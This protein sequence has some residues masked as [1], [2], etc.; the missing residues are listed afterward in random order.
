MR[1][2]IM[3]RKHSLKTSFFFELVHWGML[4][5]LILAPFVFFAVALI[6]FG[7]SDGLTPVVSEAQVVFFFCAL[8][9]VWIGLSFLTAKIAT[10][11]W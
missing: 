6:S 5:A 3:R 4:L 8:F 2:A 9:L 10:R 11:R 7:E 1:Y